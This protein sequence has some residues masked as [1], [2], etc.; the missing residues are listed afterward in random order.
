[1]L[2]EEYKACSSALCNFL[3]S[4]VIES[5]KITGWNPQLIMSLT[6]CRWVVVLRSWVFGPVFE[7]ST[8]L[9]KWGFVDR[10]RQQILE[11]S[12]PP[13]DVA[14]VRTVFPIHA[15]HVPLNF[16]RVMPFSPTKSHYTSPLFTI[17]CVP[18]FFFFFFFCVVHASLARAAY[19]T[20]ILYVAKTSNYIWVKFQH[21]SSNTNAEKNYCA[22]LFN[23]PTYNL[24]ISLHIMSPMRI[25]FSYNCKEPQETLD[26]CGFMYNKLTYAGLDHGWLARWRKWRACDVGEA[27]EGLE[28]ELW[29]KR[30]NRMVGEWAVT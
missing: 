13:G 1:M 3:H 29:R 27:K 4:P 8:T 16:T 23:Q 7:H 17:T 14:T 30:S 11:E 26:I 25:N 9:G 20:N 15:T 6:G 18:F 10:W 12:A 19:E 5:Q 21:P 22:L 2:G 24:L 28:N